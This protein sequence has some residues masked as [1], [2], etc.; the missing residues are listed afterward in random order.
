MTMGFGTVEKPVFTPLNPITE[1]DFGFMTLG[2]GGVKNLLL[3]AR[4]GE[5]KAWISQ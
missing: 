5:L 2:G 4:V 1:Y 3:H